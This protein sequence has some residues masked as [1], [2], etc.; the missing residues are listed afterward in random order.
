MW[1]IA[2]FLMTPKIQ[3][4]AAP[5]E[6]LA[7]VAMAAAPVAL[8]ELEAMIGTQLTTAEFLSKAAKLQL[9]AAPV[10]KNFAYFFI[11]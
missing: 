6:T 7:R 3:A 8:R 5:E 10:S 11:W 4:T 2:P 1:N 9:I